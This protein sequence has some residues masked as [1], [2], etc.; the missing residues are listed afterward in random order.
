M[1]SF[2]CIINFAIKNT[3]KDVGAKKRKHIL[4]K[5]KERLTQSDIR[6]VIKL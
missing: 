1:Y 4:N 6:N 3:F 5:K 2:V